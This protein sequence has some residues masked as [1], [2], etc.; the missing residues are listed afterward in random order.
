MERSSLGVREDA[1]MERKTAGVTGIPSDSDEDCCNV[2]PGVFE[3]GLV[4]VLDDELDVE[5]GIRSVI[6]QGI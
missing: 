2:G 3:A 4:T 5:E 1:K 6:K